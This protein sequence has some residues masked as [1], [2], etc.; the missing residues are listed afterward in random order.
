MRLIVGQ[1]RLIGSDF[2]EWRSG[3]TA[4]EY[5]TAMTDV[6]RGVWDADDDACI[7]GWLD[8]G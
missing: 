3:L 6:H 7:E 1:R 8:A 4:D 2:V 5:R